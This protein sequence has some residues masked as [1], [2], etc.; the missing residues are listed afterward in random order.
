[1]IVVHRF[2]ST[3]PFENLA[4]EELLLETLEVGA[5]ALVLY[6]NRPCVVLG[7]HQNP[8]REVRLDE[9]FRRGV[10]LVRR[11]SGGG[12]VWH[13]EGN[14]NWSY[15]GP[16]DTYDRGRVT[17]TVVRALG[18][19]GVAVVPGEKGD[20]FFDGKK[21][22]GAA[23][24]LKRDRALHHGTLLCRARLD[25]LRGLLGG[26]GRLVEWVGV[27]SRPS[28]VTNLGL[29]VATVADAVADAFGGGA[30]AATGP[31]SHEI[32]GFEGLVAD[33]AAGLADVAWVWDSTPP[34]TWDG[35]ILRGA[36][37]FRVVGGRIEEAVSEGAFGDLVGARFF[38]PS[39]WASAA[40]AP[41]TCHPGA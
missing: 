33:R 36:G 28:P 31:G 25:D 17:D 2:S 23:Y 16:R 13:D 7:R 30:A 40:T 20:L 3:D 12:T 34:F 5:S 21:I 37:R 26:N 19:L 18:T 6:V 27:A 4:R 11:S 22:S 38:D 39:L 41:S 1:V 29:D 15:L 14:L 9:L 35:T 8:V 24:L 10:P 32:P